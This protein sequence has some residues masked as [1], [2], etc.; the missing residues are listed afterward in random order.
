MHCGPIHRDD[1]QVFHRAL[2]RV[3]MIDYFRNKSRVENKLRRSG[4]VNSRVVFSEPRSTFSRLQLLRRLHRPAMERHSYP[5]TSGQHQQ[6]SPYSATFSQSGLPESEKH[7]D[8]NENWS[9]E[10]SG[11]DGGEDADNRD[12]SRKRR[13]RPMSVSYVSRLALR[14]SYDGSG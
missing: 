8:A 14:S 7:E 10:F 5:I 6:Q 11:G 13:R 1:D 9:E 3:Q 2:L 4:G 12:G